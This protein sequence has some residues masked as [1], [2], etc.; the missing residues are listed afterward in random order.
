M[1]DLAWIMTVGYISHL[2]RSN[3]GQVI[4]L[5]LLWVSWLGRRQTAENRTVQ[6]RAHDL[7]YRKTNNVSAVILSARVVRKRSRNSIK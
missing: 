1:L 7:E 2:V 4:T 3:L 6:P 5:R